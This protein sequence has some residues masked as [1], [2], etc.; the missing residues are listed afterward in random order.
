MSRTTCPRLGSKLG[1]AAAQQLAVRVQETP[2]RH[3]AKSEAMDL[4]RV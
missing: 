4:Q 1:Q 3:Q 2:A